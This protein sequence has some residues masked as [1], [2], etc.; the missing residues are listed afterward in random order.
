L[1]FFNPRGVPLYPVLMTRFSRIRTH[2]TRLFM[3]LLLC[4]ASD[5]SS[6]KY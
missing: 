1:Q 3:Q 5:A 2:P 4:E 6:M